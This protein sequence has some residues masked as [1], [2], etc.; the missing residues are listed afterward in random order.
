MP[1][2]FG[3][4]LRQQRLRHGIALEAI[5]KQT[6]IKES[7]LEALESDDLSHWPTGFYRRAFFRA[8]ASAIQLDPDAAFAE[9]QVTH[10]EPPEADV[11]AAMAAALG[12]GEGPSRSTA[13]RGAVGSAFTSL[14]RF[15]RAPSASSEPTASAPPTHDH[16]RTALLEEPRTDLIELARICAGFGG[17]TSAEEAQVLLPD[18]ARILGASGLI[19]WTWNPRMLQLQPALVHGYPPKVVAQLPM[20]RYDDA[21]ATAMSFR[22]TQTRVFRDSASGDCAFVVPLRTA[23]R[24]VGVLAGELDRGLDATPART[25]IAVVLA[26]QLA[27]IADGLCQ[28]EQYRLP[29]AVNGS[30]QAV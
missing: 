25:A 29:A 13:L 19:V 30:V 22:T 5:A 8:Y 4:R 27:P 6:R 21:N 18:A 26:A 3:A 15:R 24:C 10:P 17:V 9:F 14:S 1:E 7:L 28:P 2:N 12:R 20:V 11:L 23:A 16:H